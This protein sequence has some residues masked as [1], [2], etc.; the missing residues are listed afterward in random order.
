MSSNVTKHGLF[1]GLTSSISGF[2]MYNGMLGTMML[3]IIGIVV[4]ILIL[5]SAGKAYKAQNGGYAT[6]GELVKTFSLILI[7]GLLINAMFQFVYTMTM[8]EEKKDTFIETMVENQTNMVSG[9]IPEEQ[10]GEMEDQMY[11]QLSG[12][13]N[14]STILMN[15]LIGAIFSILISLIPAA[16]MKNNREEFV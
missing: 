10:I 16:I 8:S 12:M 14:P 13:F 15:L 6:M 5:V 11:E 3:S 2:L 7:I 4:F 1:Y 9:I